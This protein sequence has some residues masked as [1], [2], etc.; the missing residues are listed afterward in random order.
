MKVSGSVTIR[1]RTTSKTLFDYLISPFVLLSA[2][3]PRTGLRAF[4]ATTGLL[5]YAGI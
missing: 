5:A 4:G 3:D 1:I 2:E